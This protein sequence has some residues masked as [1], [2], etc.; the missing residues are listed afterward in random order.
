MF[1]NLLDT[2]R[3]VLKFSILVTG[4][5]TSLSLESIQSPLENVYGTMQLLH[6]SIQ[7]QAF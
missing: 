2:V 4:I 3:S 1:K 7:R 6:V 5:N